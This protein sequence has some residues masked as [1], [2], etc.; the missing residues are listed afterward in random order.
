MSEEEKCILDEEERERQ[1][2]SF[3][4]HWIKYSKSIDWK[5][6]CPDLKLDRSSDLVEDPMTIDIKKLMEAVQSVNKENIFFD[7]C[8]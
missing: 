2:K 5:Q 8:R 7:S 3:I 1:R 6:L 4:N